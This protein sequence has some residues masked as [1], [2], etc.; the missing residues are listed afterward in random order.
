ME[1]SKKRKNDTIGIDK[2]PS[3]KRQSDIGVFFKLLRK[4]DT[5]SN[6]NKESNSKK[7]LA[8]NLQAATAEK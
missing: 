8:R 5:A 6:L 1:A 3:P 4:K 7:K 2:A